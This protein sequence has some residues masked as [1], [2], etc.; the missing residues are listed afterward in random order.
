MNFESRVAFG[1]S[2]QGNPNK[3]VWELIGFGSVTTKK[4][5]WVLPQNWFLQNCFRI[6]SA[7]QYGSL[8]GRFMS[9]AKLI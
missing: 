1:L 7:F 4:P 9:S 2:K 8:V 6:E 3:Q 5:K